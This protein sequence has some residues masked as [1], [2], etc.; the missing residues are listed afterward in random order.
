[1]ASLLALSCELGLQITRLLD[2][3]DKFNFSA[4][5]KLYRAQLWPEIF[6]IIRF[7]NDKASATSALIAV[8]AHGLE[9][10]YDHVYFY[11][12][13]EEDADATRAEELQHSTSLAL[14]IM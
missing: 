10:D 11:F 4:T 9:N 3:R 5:C 1:M 13:D 7:T 6:N 8:E 14:K 12:W 2:I